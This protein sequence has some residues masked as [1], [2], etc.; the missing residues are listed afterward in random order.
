MLEILE[1]FPDRAP[2]TFAP[3]IDR[4]I[5]YYMNAGLSTKRNSNLVKESRT[6]HGLGKAGDFHILVKVSREID[7]RSHENEIPNEI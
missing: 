4:N 5:N 1:K 7:F 2:N 6:S 3:R